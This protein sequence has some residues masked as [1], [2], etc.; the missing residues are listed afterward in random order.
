MTLDQ[1]PP[2]LR[3]QAIR[4][5]SPAV[6]RDEI[7]LLPADKPAK[8]PPAARKSPHTPATPFDC[9]L[10]DYKPRTRRKPPVRPPD[11]M[12]ET[13]RLYNAEILSGAGRFEPV[14]F[15][16]AG[17]CRYTPDFLTI[18]DGVPT[19]H[20]VK[21]SYRLNSQGRAWAAFTSAAAQFPFF[22]WVWAERTAKPAGWRV[23]RR[24]E[25]LPADLPADN[26]AD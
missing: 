4:Q 6:L 19:F 16:L 15:R 11:G 5:L 14:T 20:E 1:L 21:G 23:K 18:D 24:V 2:H 8:T 3:E 12:T 17:G 25:P 22:R 10:A 9:T 26:S 7:A 13:E